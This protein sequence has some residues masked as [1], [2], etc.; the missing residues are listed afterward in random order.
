MVNYKPV[1]VTINTLELAE[2]IINVVV[3]YHGLL[4]SIISDCR[5]IFLSK[6][7]SSLCYFF[8]GK[9]KLLT[10]FYLQTDGQ[11]KQQN[12]TIEA[13]FRTFVN[14]KQNDWAKL[15]PIAEFAYSNAKN[16]SI[17]HMPFELNYDYHLWILY[18]EPVNSY[19]Q[20]KSVDKLLA[21]LRELMIV[22]QENLYYTQ[23]LQ[24]QAYDK[25]VKPWSY[26]F[27]EKI[28]L[29]SKYMKTIHNQKLET[30]FFGPFRVFYPV[31]KQAYKLELPK[32]WRIY[33]VFHMSLLE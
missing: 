29:N 26:A 3:Q 31:G 2:V 7:W 13:Y 22:Y 10:V 12:G 24:K 6:F 18:K 33:D 23:E 19:S 5:A 9:W 1:K 14:F 20:S 21:E 28:W 11:T 27:D 16:T 30:K 15:L 32:K 25:G 8:G 17:G 4:D